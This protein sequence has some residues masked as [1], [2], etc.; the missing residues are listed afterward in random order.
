MI[1]KSQ[2][3]HSAFIVGIPTGKRSKETGEVVLFTD[4]QN[5]KAKNC[6]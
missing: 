5:I 2:Q 6:W 3:K 1:K 4:F